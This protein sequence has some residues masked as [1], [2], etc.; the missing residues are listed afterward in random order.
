MLNFSF[1][2]LELPTIFISNT[3]KEFHERVEL[4]NDDFQLGFSVR[5]QS[6]VELLICSG[7]DPYNYPC[8]YMKI[9][10][11]TIFLQK[12]NAL[13]KN[14]SD[15]EML[16]HYRVILYFK[17]VLEVLLVYVLGFYKDFTY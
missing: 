5:S 11:F 6:F 15:L 3:T 7:W 12:Y 13:P 4:S 16:D 9:D 10:N 14:I 1:L 8:Y 17:L 2:S